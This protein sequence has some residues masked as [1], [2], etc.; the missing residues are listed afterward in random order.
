MVLE[1]LRG[2]Q[3]VRKPYADATPAQSIT[4]FLRDKD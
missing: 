2:A 3:M 4:A 1:T